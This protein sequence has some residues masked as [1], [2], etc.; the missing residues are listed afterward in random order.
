[1]SENNNFG[2]DIRE[3][4]EEELFRLINNKANQFAVI[5]Q[6]ELMRRLSVQDSES[7]KRNASSS[8]NIAVA[9]I[10]S[11]ILIGLFQIYLAKIQVDPILEQRYWKE[12][13][14]YEFC[15]EPGN[16]NMEDGGSTPNSDCKEVYLQ[17]KSNF[18]KYPPAEKI[19]E[20]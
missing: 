6:Y 7:S 20:R 17:L 15:K 14:Q 5:A 11:S 2:K 1:M 19:L 18:G 13:N 8:R 10:V 12:K 3:L 16:W 4:S 9:A